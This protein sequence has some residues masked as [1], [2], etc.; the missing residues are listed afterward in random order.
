METLFQVWGGFFYLLS[1]IFFSRAERS[2]E[3]DARKVLRA[4]AWITYLIGL[5]AIVLLFILNSNWIAMSVEAAG[6]VS[7]V[8]GLLTAIVGINKTP[9]WLNWLALVAALAGGAYSFYDFHGITTYTQLLEIGTVIGFLSGTYLLARDD[10]RGY[11]G[12]ILMNVSTFGLF[13]IQDCQI[14][15][16]Q[17]VISLGFVIDAFVM[18]MRR[19]KESRLYLVSSSH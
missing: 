3:K 10:S 19:R 17:Q 2:K 4:F 18:N 1:K 13:F 5:P 9:K 6:G 7:M 15:A 14:M 11:V 12:F 8:F 16:V